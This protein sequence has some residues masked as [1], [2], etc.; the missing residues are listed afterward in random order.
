[1]PSDE[2]DDTSGGDV[3]Q[4]QPS[5]VP[6]DAAGP[7]DPLLEALRQESIAKESEQAELEREEAL[8][9]LNPIDPNTGMPYPEGLVGEDQAA[10]M[11]AEDGLEKK[12][13]PIR[14]PAKPR[15]PRK[16]PAPEDKG[17]T[18]CAAPVEPVGNLVFR[19]KKPAY[20]GPTEFRK[21]TPGKNEGWTY[22]GS[23]DGG[24]CGKVGLSFRDAPLQVVVK[25]D[26]K[27][28]KTRTTTK[29]TIADF[30]TEH[31]FEGFL[32]GEFFEQLRPDRTQDWCQ[33]YKPLLGDD[34]F[35]TIINKNGKKEPKY[36]KSI[37]TRLYEEYPN[38]QADRKG[39]FEMLNGHLNKLK[40]RVSFPSIL[41]AA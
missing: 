1:M 33:K 28:G 35:I 24:D 40:Y 3:D 19:A 6:E 38:N 15:G 39:E 25:Q 17:Y 8:L 12:G 4:S 31:L 7:V 5:G 9:A 16:K 14:K 32:L 10:E 29:D 36:F 27:T 26:P 22:S 20:P 37:F 11:V 18:V 30:N 23:I 21:S 2:G 34:Y 41:T 13:G